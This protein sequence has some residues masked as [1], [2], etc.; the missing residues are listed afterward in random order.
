MGKWGVIFSKQ[1]LKDYQRIKDAGLAP[2]VKAL[3][4]LLEE[5]PFQTP[6]H[7]EKLVGDLGG[8]YSRRINIRHRIVY[9]VRQE[10]HQVII[11]RLWTHYDK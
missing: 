9:A 6:P 8:Y 10:E 5:N 7:Y 4:A 3:A 1:A 11:L 2:K